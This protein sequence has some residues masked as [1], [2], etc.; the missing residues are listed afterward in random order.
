MATRTTPATIIPCQDWR[1]FSNQQWM[2]QWHVDSL[3]NTTERMHNKDKLDILTDSL[4][5]TPP[6]ATP[7]PAASAA[8]AAATDAD[9]TVVVWH[10]FHR[11]HWTRQWHMKRASIRQ[12]TMLWLTPQPDEQRSGWDL[13]RRGCKSGGRQS[14]TTLIGRPRSIGLNGKTG[15]VSA[16][17]LK[18]RLRKLKITVLKVHN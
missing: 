4:D 16:F 10:I 18:R 11:L 8:A 2:I 3:T 15:R 6:F 17:G 9:T 1:L 5:R 13:T 12:S 14:N 7:V